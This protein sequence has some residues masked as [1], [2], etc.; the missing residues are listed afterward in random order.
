M[1]SQMCKDGSDGI[2]HQPELNIVQSIA[3]E[4]LC[5]RELFRTWT[6]RT[7]STCIWLVL[8]FPNVFYLPSNKW[9]DDPHWLCIPNLFSRLKNQPGTIG[10]N[11]TSGMLAP[12]WAVTVP[13]PQGVLRPLKPTYGGFLGLPRCGRTRMVQNHPPDRHVTRI[14]GMNG[15]PLHRFAHVPHRFWFFVPWNHILRFILCG[16]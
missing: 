10:L 12:V 8:F 4:V 3:S 16:P 11:S 7:Q 2:S 5:T 9:E 1:Y 14:M 6:R 15:R 13:R